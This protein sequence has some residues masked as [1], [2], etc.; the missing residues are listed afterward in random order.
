MLI[1]IKKNHVINKLHKDS[2]NIFELVDIQ[3]YGKMYQN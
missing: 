2:P 1:M 3:W